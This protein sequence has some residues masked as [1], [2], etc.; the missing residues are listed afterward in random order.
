MLFFV[1]GPNA[2]VPPTGCD[3]L[4]VTLAIG[5]VF[6]NV[7]NQIERTSWE[8]Y[9]NNAGADIIVVTGPLDHGPIATSRSPAWQKLLVLDQPWAKRYARVLWLDADIIIS[10][11]ALNIFDYAPHPE[12]IA[13][14]CSGDRLSPSEKQIYI[15]LQYK[16]C[17]KPERTEQMWGTLTKNLYVE[18]EVP[19]HTEMF[20][21]GVMVLSPEHHNALFLDV[22][23]HNDQ[24]RL[25]EQPRLSHEIMERGLADLVPARFNWGLQETLIMYTRGWDQILDPDARRLILGFL[26]EAELAK[27]YFLHFYGTMDV[28]KLYLP[29]AKAA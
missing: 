25:Y 20:N 12:K 15:E 4:I 5:D 13:L 28:L 26:V 8:N 19:P 23:Q 29:D 21:T 24:G 11:A 10:R 18:S 1:D 17:L 3:K 7:W 2:V 6:F 14:C 27:A 9:A 16:L 22:Y